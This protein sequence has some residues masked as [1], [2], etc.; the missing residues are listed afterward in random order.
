MERL[1]LQYQLFNSSSEKERENLNFLIADKFLNEGDYESAANIN[2][3][4]LESADN[5]DMKYFLS[6]KS[7]F[8]VDNYEGSQSF[9]NLINEKKLNNNYLK[10]LQLYKLLNFN[11]LLLIDSTSNQLVKLFI[12]A[13]KDTMGLKREIIELA[14]PKFLNLKK[15]R[16]K[17]SIFPGAGLWY[18]G[19]KKRAVTSSLINI[20]ALGY[21]AYSIYTKYYITAVLTGGAQFMRFYKGGKKAS[22]KIG[23][24]KNRI[25]YIDYVIKLDNYCE[26]KLI[27][28]YQ[29]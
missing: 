18:V 2:A 12:N 11:H 6:G 16:R 25:K 10:E 26:Q 24:T 7:E 4:I 29:K 20:A 19:E 28:L 14:P 8:L 17:S 23:A 27:G 5:I 9:L 13:G 3:K 1:A 15:A 22:I 21:A